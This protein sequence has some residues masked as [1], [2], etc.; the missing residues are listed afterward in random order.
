MP[1][2]D[3]ANLHRLEDSERKAL[4]RHLVENQ[5]KMAKDLQTRRIKSINPSAPANTMFDQVQA[6][7][8]AWDA[9]SKLLAQLGPPVESQK[10]EFPSINNNLLET[11][12]QLF[13]EFMNRIKS[14]KIDSIVSK[15]VFYDGGGGFSKVRIIIR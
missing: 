12:N 1:A 6:N 2:G 9:I 13:R 3:N 14:R 8:K 5:E 4:H 7:R 15:G 10:K 11:N